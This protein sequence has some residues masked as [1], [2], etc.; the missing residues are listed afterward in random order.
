MMR[1]RQRTVVAGIDVGGEAKGFDAVALTEGKVSAQLSSTDAGAVAAWCKDIGARAVGVDAPICWSQTG[2]ARAAEQELMAAG[3]S[4]FSTPS[5]EQAKCHPTNYYGWM[6]NGAKLYRSLDQ[7]YDRFKGGKA[8][9]SPVCFE[10]FPQAVACA[11]AGKVVQA[12]T[13]RAVRRGL[14]EQAGVSCS[15]LTH[16]DAIDAA[17]CALAARYFLNGRYRIYGE[18]REGF[19]VVPDRNGRSGGEPGQAIDLR[20][21]PLEPVLGDQLRTPAE[22]G[23]GLSR[24]TWP[25]KAHHAACCSEL[26]EYRLARVLVAS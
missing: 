20:N 3:I 7:H 19:I 21:R 23:A 15:P 18:P 10:T 22:G 8:S 25:M 2:R 13:K 12:R 17:M 5:A 16:I 1:D 4:C 11:L 9:R 24:K 26:S 6:L 14:L